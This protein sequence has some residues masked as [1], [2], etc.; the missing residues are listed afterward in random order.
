MSDEYWIGYAFGFYGGLSTGAIVMAAVLL[1]SCA[2]QE[3]KPWCGPYAET[4]TTN[5]CTTCRP[6]R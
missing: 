5:Q 3:R 6:E 2:H 1:S 4:T